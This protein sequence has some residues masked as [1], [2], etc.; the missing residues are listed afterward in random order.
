M[1][2]VMAI[3]RR[4]VERGTAYHSAISK[5]YGKRRMP[6]DEHR[7]QCSGWGTNKEREKGTGMFG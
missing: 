7:M 5:K 3:G 6:I 1:K 2:Y 4:R